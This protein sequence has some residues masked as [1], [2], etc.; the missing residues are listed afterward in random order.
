MNDNTNKRTS[1]LLLYRRRYKP[2]DEMD[3]MDIVPIIPVPSTYQRGRKI[4]HDWH[5]EIAWSIDFRGDNDDT[6]TLLFAGAGYT[7]IKKVFGSLIQGSLPFTGYK[8]Y[9]DYYPYQRQRRSYVRIAVELYNF[10]S[11]FISLSDFGFL[12]QNMIKKTCLCNI[13]MLHLDKLLN[14]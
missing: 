14:V 3:V 11:D 9:R 7:L 2:D 12:I 6:P 5:R 1:S 8:L 13:K 10:N 4:Q